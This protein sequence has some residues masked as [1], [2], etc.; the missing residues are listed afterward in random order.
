MAKT[1][2]KPQAKPRDKDKTRAELLLAI[3]RV[4]NKG[5]TLSISAVAAEVEVDPSLVHHTYPD[6]AEQIRKLTGR[7][8]RQQRDSKQKQLTELKQ[9]YRELEAE[10]KGLRDDVNRLSSINL[11]LE[12]ELIELRAALTGKVVLLGRGALKP[13]EKV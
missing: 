1:P 11:T 2:V 6:I 13:P 3:Q 9:A 8:A 4:Q 7:A 10:A 12:Q 5:I